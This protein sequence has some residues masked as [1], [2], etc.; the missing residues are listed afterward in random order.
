MLLLTTAKPIVPVP[1]VGLH[2]LWSLVRRSV[3]VELARQAA[4]CPQTPLGTGEPSPPRCR[5]R[6]VAGSSPLHGSSLFAPCMDA[7]MSYHV[8]CLPAGPGR[9]LGPRYGRSS[10]TLSSKVAIYYRISTG[11]L[12]CGGAGPRNLTEAT[13]QQ[14]SSYKASPPCSLSGRLGLMFKNTGGG[15]CNTISDRVAAA[16]VPTALLRA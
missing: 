10:R 3:G 16:A 7:C 12:R 15:G 4:S 11:R 6:P 1:K 2:E 14:S 9:C 5:Q 13:P 8:M